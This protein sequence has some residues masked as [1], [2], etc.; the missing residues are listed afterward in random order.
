ME[1]A[2]RSGDSWHVSS[3]RRLGGG[4]GQDT[5]IED[6]GR[7]YHSRHIELPGT[8]F[9]ELV[10]GRFLHL[11]QM[12]VGTW[13]ANICGVT[14]WIRADRDGK[15]VSISVSGPGDYANAEPGCEYR[16]EWSAG[17][18]WTAPSSAPKSA[19]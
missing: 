8:D 3:D 10:V 5:S 14:L 13:W 6:G 4:D 19:P 15:P 7:T 12:D 16:L 1:P 11:E 9:D 18:E 2:G 17:D